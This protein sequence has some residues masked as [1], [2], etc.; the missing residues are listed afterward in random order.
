M[1][2][3]NYRHS[4]F[5]SVIERTFSIWKAWFNIFED[6]PSYPIETHRLFMV[7]CCAAHNFINKHE[8]Q[9]NPLFKLYNRCTEKIGSM[10]HYVIIC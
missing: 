2:L 8:G 4:S 6:M 5:Q 10:C 9:T 3:F 1:E 7:A